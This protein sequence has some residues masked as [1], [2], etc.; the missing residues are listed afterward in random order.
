MA[1]RQGTK[2]F[3][4]AVEGIIAAFGIPLPQSRIYKVLCGHDDVAVLTSATVGASGLITDVAGRYLMRLL[5]RS[6][7][8]R[9]VAAFCVRTVL[10]HHLVVDTQQ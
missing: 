1:R 6:R 5:V 8:K 9:R 3:R 10:F 4:T 2:Q 7:G